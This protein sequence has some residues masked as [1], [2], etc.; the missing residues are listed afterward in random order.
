MSTQL[1]RNGAALLLAALLATGC[2]DALSADG[3]DG[4]DGGSK[5]N[6]TAVVT[7]WPQTELAGTATSPIVQDINIGVHEVIRSADGL[8]TVFLDVENQT[9]DDLSLYD[10]V[11]SDTL[12]EVTLLDTG[13]KTRYTPLQLDDGAGTCVCSGDTR[14]VAGTTTRL[15]VTYA[16]LPEDIGKVRIGVPGFTPVDGVGIQRVG[17]FATDDT[18]ALTVEGNDD[19]SVRVQSV[20][21]GDE[22][23]TVVRLEYRNERADPVSPS[24]FPSP[25]TIVLVDPDK[26]ITYQIRTASSSD[27]IS[28]EPTDQID[29]GES[30]TRDLLMAPVPDSV[31]E[32]LVRGRGLH[33]SFPVTVSEKPVDPAFDVT[34]ALDD[35]ET[36]QLVQDSGRYR[37]EAV[38][39]AK[40]SDIEVDETGPEL[41]AGEPVGT[42]ASPAQPGWTFAPRN[43]VRVSDEQSYLA[44]DMTRSGTD[45]GW[46]ESV[47]ETF[48]DDL[49]SIA[50]IDPKTDQRLG[51]LVGERDSFTSDY[52]NG[53]DEGE[54]HTMFVAFPAPAD[55]SSEVTVDIPSFGQLDG[56]P[57]VD[58]PGLA[59]KND[60]VQATMRTSYDDRLRMDVLSVGRMS[61][62][63]GT[64]VRVR[65]VN[66]SNPDGVNTPFGFPGYEDLCRISLVNPDNNDRFWALDP[67][68]ATN[69]QRDLGPDD[70]L[71]F[72]VRFPNVPDGAERMV[73]AAD[74]FVP[75]APVNFADS[76]SPWYLDLPRDSDDP[77][78]DTLQGSVG[79]ADDLQTEVRSGSEVEVNLNTDVLFE[80]GSAT[81]GADA[82]A[83]LGE[84]A[85]RL[86]DDA[87]GVVTITGHTDNV[88]DDA[89]NLTLSQQRAEAV[90]TVL[91]ER[92][93]PSLVLEVDAKG[94][95]EPVA[96]NDIEGRDNPDG[97]ARNR[98]VTVSY[99]AG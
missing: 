65:M 4:N 26:L 11:G 55:G 25:D 97:R 6:S 5:G 54:T 39:M 33:R 15:Y 80:F 89:G 56:V 35:P 21:R 68:I 34:S 40:P 30:F 10:L 95:A 64:L 48:N 69:W 28:E 38:S 81:L 76:A 61:N 14:L 66:E 82:K 13:G 83:R 91:A 57:V 9:N 17:D 58:G 12:Q 8:S 29:G 47:T 19:L 22:D 53:L 52:E 36:Y 46:P 67:C 31:D 45:D 24:D 44:V 60:P 99:T 51:A 93:G 27:V 86:S 84:V 49:R 72:E 90:K 20:S 7:K 32:V 59:G 85:D 79:V 2:T 42:L 23:G 71:V 16:D 18:A 92:A 37:T 62:D 78:G 50:L 75:S 1:R 88:G 43:V 96:P 70:S 74:G 94:E 87:S 3:K 73:V 77:V 98:R 41:P 63:G